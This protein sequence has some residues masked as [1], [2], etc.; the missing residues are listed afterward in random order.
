M[1]KKQQQNVGMLFLAS[2]SLL[3][4]SRYFPANGST[5]LDF[6]QGIL[7]GVGI[8]GMVMTIVTFGRYYKRS[9]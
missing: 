6:T 1:D 8:G 9:H 4:V 2:F 5:L 7:A 3:T